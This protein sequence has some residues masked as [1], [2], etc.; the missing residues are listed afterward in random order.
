[1][2]FHRRMWAGRNDQANARVDHRRFTSP[3]NGRLGGRPSIRTREIENTICC[4]IASGESI[5]EICRDQEMSARDTVF[6][7]LRD[8]A[9]RARMR[10]MISPEKQVFRPIRARACVRRSFC[11]RPIPSGR[12]SGCRRDRPAEPGEI[13]TVSR[14]GVE[15]NRRCPRQ[16]LPGS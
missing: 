5:R 8:D 7:W 16:S 13:A 2:P 11:L 12:P 4:R 1:M 6:Q 14:P 9:R 15:R 3:Q 10:M